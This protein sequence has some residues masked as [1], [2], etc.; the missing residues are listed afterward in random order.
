MNTKRKQALERWQRLSRE[1]QD[2][3]MVEAERKLAERIRKR[4]SNWSRFQLQ[5]E[6]RAVHNRLRAARE[7]ALGQALY[8]RLGQLESAAKHFAEADAKS[9]SVFRNQYLPTSTSILK[10]L[11]RD[12]A[13]F[14][15]SSLMQAL[16][17]KKCREMGVQL[18]QV[19]PVEF[20]EY[21]PLVEVDDGDLSRNYVG[22]HWY[23]FPGEYGVLPTA[24]ALQSCQYLKFD[25]YAFS[26]NSSVLP[27]P[28]VIITD[29]TLKFVL[30]AQ[31]CDAIVEW[32]AAP[33]IDLMMGVTVDADSARLQIN[34]FFL[35]QPES[36]EFPTESQLDAGMT[37]VTLYPELDYNEET[38]WLW[39]RVTRKAVISGSYIAKAGVASSVLVGVEVFAWAE[40]GCACIGDGTNNPNL[41]GMFRFADPFGCY[42]PPGLEH[43]CPELTH[44][45]MYFT[46]HPA[47]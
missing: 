23:A 1:E 38:G 18:L 41:D 14:E 8:A 32:C 33:I 7:P 39:N 9:G 21:R 19:R 4:D 30:P 12:T 11:S 28:N 15:L 6:I 25:G 37:F 24:A 36:A 17:D 43:L 46:V 13:H 3:L 31:P 2:R 40:D 45:A 29:G 10:L 44:P 16:K 22:S 5:S 35:Q 47:A 42:A 20:K 34:M 27:L 26:N